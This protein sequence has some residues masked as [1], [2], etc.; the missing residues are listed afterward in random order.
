M[1]GSESIPHGSRFKRSVGV[2]LLPLYT[3]NWLFSKSRHLAI[4]SDS[5]KPWPMTLAPTNEAIRRE[6]IRKN[7]GWVYGYYLSI[8]ITLVRVGDNYFSTLFIYKGCYSPDIKSS[9]FGSAL[10]PDGSICMN[11]CDS[12]WLFAVWAFCFAED[13]FFCQQYLVT[14]FIIIIN[15]LAVYAC[16][17]K[18]SLALPVISYFVPVSSEWN[19]EEHV[20]S[21]YCCAWRDFKDCVI[22]GVNGPSCV[23]KK[24]I[25]IIWGN[26]LC[27]VELSCA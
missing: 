18:I 17:V 16:C 13:T 20:T 15:L 3:S 9:Q 19:V 7:Q 11:C 14:N 25:N 4:L 21:K 24:C 10:N 26:C 1:L 23:V 27:H 5:T 22:G 12:P 8:S 6:T 2:S